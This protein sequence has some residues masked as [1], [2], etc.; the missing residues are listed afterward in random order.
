MTN[1]QFKNL[2]SNP[3]DIMNPTFT[4]VTTDNNLGQSIQLYDDTQGCMFLQFN[5]TP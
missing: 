3:Y 4:T 5:G 1:S 2:N